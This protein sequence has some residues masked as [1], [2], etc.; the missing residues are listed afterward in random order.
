MLIAYVDD[1]KA[2]MVR[3]VVSATKARFPTEGIKLFELV[4]AR[5]DL[6]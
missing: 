1:D 6:T 4:E 2:R 3:E 5:D